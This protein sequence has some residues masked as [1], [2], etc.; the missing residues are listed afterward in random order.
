MRSLQ[1][2][3]QSTVVC[4][5]TPAPAP[6]P[7]E[8]LIQTQVSAL[9]GSELKPYHGAGMQMGNTGHESAGIVAQLGPDV[10]QLKEGQRVGVSAVAGCGACTYCAK[11]Q[12]TYC[13]DLVTHNSMHAEYF[14]TKANACHLLP[15]ELSWEV[16]LLI[17]GDGFGVPYHTST[18][19][20]NEPIESVAIFGMGPIGLG[21]ALLHSHLG[22]QVIA[23]DVVAK[24]LEFA[25]ELGA[26]H[27]L[28]ASKDLDP[29]AAIRELTAGRGADVCIEAAGRPES[30]KQCFAAVRTAGTVAFNGEQPAIELSPSADFI[31]RDITALGSWYYHFGQFPA[32]LE[33][34]RRGLAVDRLITHRFPFAEA[35]EA[36][37]M[38][39]AGQTGKV[40]LE[41]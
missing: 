9:C 35:P 29:V 14:I 1:M 7:G 37:R 32:M 4:I 13:P 23:V 20:K 8:V 33:L 26:A 5:D 22:R 3:G 27:V 41:Y 12:Y 24:R 38:M 19:L 6:G 30:A 28:Q 10:T 17:S 16:G 15:D 39:A 31:R 25:G 11:G 21:N 34:Y 18:K 2:P 40:L 36:F